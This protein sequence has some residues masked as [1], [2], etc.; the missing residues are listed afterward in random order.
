MI[1]DILEHTPVWLWALS[2]AAWVIGF[3]AMRSAARNVVAVR[4]ATSTAT[5]AGAWFVYG[6]RLTYGA[7]VV[8]SHAGQ[9]V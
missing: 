6:C 3:A 2:L 1:I 4:G 8:G 7:V 5:D 9:P